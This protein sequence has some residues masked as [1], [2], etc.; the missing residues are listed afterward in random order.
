MP[1]PSYGLPSSRCKTGSKL[2][3]V[4][5]SVCYGCY[6]ADD[7]DW[8]KQT[9]RYTNYAFNNVKKANALRF[10][11][12]HKDLWVPAMVAIILKQKPQYFRWHDT[13]DLQSVEHLENIAEI[14]RN[15]P[16]TRHWLP[17]R[18]YNIVRQWRSKFE[19]PSN[20]CIRVSA[21]M[22]DKKA[23]RELG[24]SSMV[25]KDKPIPDGV[26]ECEAYK[27]NAEC[28]DCRSCWNKSVETISYPYH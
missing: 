24:N 5:G 10:E 6:A 16:D 3:S 9:K 14:C 7:W 4:E 28:G 23:P 21:H 25:S 15:T 1:G 26:L 22:H 2:K 12:I 11:A 20:L 8:A 27:R 18:E 19:E 17:T 13:G